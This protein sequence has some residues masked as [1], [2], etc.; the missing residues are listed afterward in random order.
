MRTA[1]QLLCVCLFGASLS[2]TQ[3]QTAVFPIATNTAVIELSGGVTFDGANY[4]VGMLIGT[5]LAMQRVS[6]AGT[7]LGAPVSVGANPGLPPAVA[8]A[9]GQTNHLIAWSDVT[10]TSGVTMF[11]QFVSRE[12]A[13]VGPV[14]N[15]LSSAGAHGF[16]A[17]KAL[18]TDGTNFLAVWQDEKNGWFYGQRISP[19]GALSGPALLISGQQGNSLDAAVAFGRTN[20]LVVWQS[21][22]G[23]V[24]STNRAFGSLVSAGGSAGS[25]FQISQTASPDQNPPAV[26]FDG[27]NYLVAW[28]HN[29]EPGSG[30]VTNWNIHGRLVSSAGTFPGGEVVLV[31]DP[32]SQVLPSLAFDGD[33]YLLVWGDGTFNIPN[34]TMR[35]RFFNRYASA[36]GPAFALFAAQGANAPLMALNGALFDG[37]RFFVAATLGTFEFGFD[38]DV[39]GFSSGDVHGTFIPA[40]TARPAL[41]AAGPRAGAQ[42]PL[43][44]TG[45]PGI[46]YVIQA[47]TNLTAGSWMSLTTNS[48]ATGAFSFTDTQA[49]NHNRFYRALKL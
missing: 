38:N 35:F 44:L 39:V 32:G 4:G 41:T 40:S 25:P 20:Y 30:V 36:A 24:G 19:A 6:A 9:F 11:G 34:P 7:L 17:V 5:N 23:Q 42:F 29:N 49:T 48:P 2:E 22:N 16:Q 15:L 3:A 37:S 43:L 28:N 13:K 1:P 14:F 21:D 10:R 18:A 26:A 33:S 31:S 47:A 27:T 8:F 12:G 45:T 46:N